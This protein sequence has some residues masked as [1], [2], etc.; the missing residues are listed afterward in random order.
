[1]SSALAPGFMVLH[2]H[3]LESLRDVVLAWLRAYP[4]DPMAEE[5]VLVQSNGMAQWL[6]AAMAAESDAEV[7]G[8]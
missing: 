7:P 8:L 3:R 5:R 4:I 2:S 1:M 6:K